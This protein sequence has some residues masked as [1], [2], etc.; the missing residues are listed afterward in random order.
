MCVLFRKLLTALSL[1][2]AGHKKGVFCPARRVP[3]ADECKLQNGHADTSAVLGTSDL[4]HSGT[5]PNAGRISGRLRN[6]LNLAS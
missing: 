1:V 4:R 3:L 6:T 5:V 2:S